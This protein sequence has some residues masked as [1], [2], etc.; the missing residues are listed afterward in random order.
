MN[1]KPLASAQRGNLDPSPF[2]ISKGIKAVDYFFVTAF[3]S[4]L[5]SEL[6]IA[7]SHTCGTLQFSVFQPAISILKT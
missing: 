7:C 6:L 3:V 4:R 2:T 1:I 5:L